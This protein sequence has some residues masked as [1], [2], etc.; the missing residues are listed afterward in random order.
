MATQ[1]ERLEQIENALLVLAGGTAGFGVGRRGVAGVAGAVGRPLLGTP[2]GRALL[3]GIT[4]DQ[5]V[6]EV[7][8]RDREIAQAEGTENIFFEAQRRLP[9][10]IPMLPGFTA[11][12]AKKTRK[13]TV[14]KFNKAVKIGMATVKKSKSFGKPGTFSNSKKAFAT[15][16]KVASALT[17]GRK[18]PKTGI[19]G[20]IARAMKKLGALHKKASEKGSGKGFYAKRRRGKKK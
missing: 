7:L 2:A 8:E 6:Q 14:S 20:K 18:A 4:Y 10:P 3:A 1:K 11:S 16:T 9:G 19:R 5:L 15:V 13:K 12:Q 17:K